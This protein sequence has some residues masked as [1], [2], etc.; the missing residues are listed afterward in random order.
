MKYRNEIIEIKSLQ[1]KK[2]ILGEIE[3]LISI[4]KYS[5]T[6]NHNNQ[7]I[8]LKKGV[9]AKVLA[10]E[11]YNNDF[12]YLELR[13]YD[14]DFFDASQKRVYKFEKKDN[15]TIL[16]G[17]LN[18]DLKEQCFGCEINENIFCLKIK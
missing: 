15:Q 6:K 5:K 1:K 4:D 2:M 16:K 14:K 3:Y 7:F 10:I 9:F 17:N 8:F 13:V 18:V 11:K 12:Y